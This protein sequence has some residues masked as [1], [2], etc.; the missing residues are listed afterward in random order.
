MIAPALMVTGFASLI[1]V[2]TQLALGGGRRG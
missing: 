2:L 1:I